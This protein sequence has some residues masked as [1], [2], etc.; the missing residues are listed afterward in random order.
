[1]IMQSNFDSKMSIKFDKNEQL[2]K[3]SL[4]DSSLV[5]I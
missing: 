3:S 5:Q 2:R 1:M 4:Q